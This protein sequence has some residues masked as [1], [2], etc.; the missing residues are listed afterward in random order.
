MVWLGR[1]MSRDPGYYAFG[2]RLPGIWYGRILGHC[3]RVKCEDHP[4]GGAANSAD[5]GPTAMMVAVEAY[6]VRRWPRN[7][8][9]LEKR[10]KTMN[11]R[12]IA[13]YRRVLQAARAKLM[14]CDHKA[15]RFD[16]ERTSDPT[17]EWDIANER[18]LVS[19]RLWRRAVLLRQIES[20]L[21]RIAKGEFG[22]CVGCQE[23]ISEKRLVALPWSALCLNCQEAA[24]NRN[25]LR[26][27]ATLA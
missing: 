16:M 20:A 26:A 4:D 22:A 18:D 23:P 13:R 21:E 25:E 10:R 3:N 24:D 19:D 17:E 7:V 14:A 15:G 1:A 12:N 5:P 2:P 11:Q 9:T 6:C 27:E 8:L